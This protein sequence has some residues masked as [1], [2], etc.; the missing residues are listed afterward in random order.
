MDH[1]GDGPLQQKQQ[2]LPGRGQ[3]AHRPPFRGRGVG[4]PA[5]RHLLL[6]QGLET[7]SCLLLPHPLQLQKPEGLRQLQSGQSADRV[8]PQEEDHLPGHVQ[9]AQEPLR[10]HQLQDHIRAA[11]REIDRVEPHL[12]LDN[13]PQAGEQGQDHSAAEVPSKQDIP[14]VQLLPHQARAGVRPHVLRHRQNHQQEQHP[15]QEQQEEGVL[16]TPRRPQNP[17]VPPLLQRLRLRLDRRQRNGLRA[18]TKRGEHN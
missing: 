15:R 1:R 9:T 7:E 12:L 3:G 10:P 5:G 4:P 14:D 17:Q 16:G 6:R 11:V 13:R 18:L 8:V 2:A